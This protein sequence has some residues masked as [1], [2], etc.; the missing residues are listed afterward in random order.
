MKIQFKG[1]VSFSALTTEKT[2]AAQHTHNSRHD[3]NIVLANSRSTSKGKKCQRSP[4]VVKSTSSSFAAKRTRTQQPVRT[5]MLQVY[6]ERLLEQA[7][8]IDLRGPQDF[9]STNLDEAIVMF[10]TSCISEF[11]QADQSSRKVLWLASAVLRIVADGSLSPRAM[12]DVEKEDDEIR[13]QRLE[14]ANSKSALASK[15]GP[16]PLMKHAN[17]DEDQAFSNKR[18]PALISGRW[19]TG[20]FETR[21]SQR[22]LLE[23]SMSA[24]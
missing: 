5:L 6:S 4:V 17:P 12:G 20:Q 11:A 1:H 15:L 23:S 9:R 2:S 19:Q 10:G 13:I 14:K 22:S 16:P 7:R 18:L 21:P 24:N 3:E 8:P